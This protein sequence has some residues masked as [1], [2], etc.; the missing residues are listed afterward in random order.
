MQ[1]AG[2][3]APHREHQGTEAAAAAAAAAAPVQL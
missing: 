3:A 2:V 1:L